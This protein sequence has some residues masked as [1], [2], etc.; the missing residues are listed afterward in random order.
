MDET[1][2]TIDPPLYLIGK[3]YSC[4][5]CGGRMPVVALLATRVEGARGEICTLSG[6]TELP[7]HIL[8]YIQ[9]RV[10]TFR[11]KFSK[12]VGQKYFANTCPRCGML[13]GDFHLHCEPG[14]AFFPT[15]ED[16][17]ASLYI[18]EIPVS[19]RIRIR[20]ACGVGCGDLIV[21]NARRIQ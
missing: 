10:P 5:R 14:A 17:A 16:D 15:N 11:L 7:D 21:D 19:D 3:M 8:A 20:A 9:G 13:S 4:W 1:R 18:T 2:L 6:I 12:T